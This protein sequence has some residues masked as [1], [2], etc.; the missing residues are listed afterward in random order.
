MGLSVEAQCPCGY[1]AYADVGAGMATFEQECRFPFHCPSCRALV[2][3]D[4]MAP[5][6]TCPQCGSAAI[7]SYADPSLAGDRGSR[8]LASSEGAAQDDDDE[9]SPA[10]DGR[11]T[12]ASCNPGGD[13]SKPLTLT[14]GGY[15]CPSCVGS[16]LHF[17][18]SCCWD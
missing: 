5:S 14:D 8:E 13:S 3:A 12:V 1:H 11:R 16:D 6:I 17:E 2:T 4:T 9:L 18:M 10:A 7:V 15:L